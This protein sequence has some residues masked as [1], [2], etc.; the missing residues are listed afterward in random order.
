MRKLNCCI[1][2][3]QLRHGLGSIFVVAMIIKTSSEMNLSWFDFLVKL[4]VTVSWEQGCKFF[5]LVFS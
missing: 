5:L 2:L 1:G 4:E 3:E